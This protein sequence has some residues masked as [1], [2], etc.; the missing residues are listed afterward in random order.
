MTSSM[1]GRYAGCYL[2]TS[3]SHN[4][5]GLECVIGRRVCTVGPLYHDLCCAFFPVCGVCKCGGGRP[6]GDIWAAPFSLIKEGL[7]LALFSLALSAET[8][9]Q[10]FH[11]PRRVPVMLAAA[12]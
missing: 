10:P 5:G 6:V 9:R 8:V 2:W 7:N 11:W 1:Q 4:G 12:L 3:A